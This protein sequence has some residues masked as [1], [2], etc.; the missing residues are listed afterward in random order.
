MDNDG[1]DDDNGNEENDFMGGGEGA[2][3][4]K[5]ATVLDMA[6]SWIFQEVEVE[7]N[8]KSKIKR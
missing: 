8:T 6:L 7:L 5:A 3:G 2:R 1:N 4:V